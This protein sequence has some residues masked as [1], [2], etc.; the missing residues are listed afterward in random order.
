MKKI[1]ALSLFLATTGCVPE[2]AFAYD[3]YEDD[4][5][6]VGLYAYAVKSPE[7]VRIF[8]ICQSSCT[9]LLAAQDVCVSPASRFMFHAA[10][11]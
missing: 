2:P 8:G 7:P 11:G 1:I 9:M 6:L 4:G 5:G 10:H 3:I